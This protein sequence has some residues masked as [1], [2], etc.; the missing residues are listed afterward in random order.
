MESEEALN[1]YINEVKDTNNEIEIEEEQVP[2]E[3]EQA[4]DFLQKVGLSDLT[5]LYN[6]G[7]EITE[8]VVSDSVRQKHLTERQAET[9]RSRIRTLNKTLHSRQPRRKQRQDIRDVAWNVET[10]STGTRSR[11]AT[12]DSLD[13]VGILNDDLTSDEDQ[14]S[15]L[16]PFPLESS[17]PVFKAKVKWTSSEPLQ[18]KKLSRDK[19]DVAHLGSENVILKGYQPLNEYSTLPRPQRERSGSDPTTEVHLQPLKNRNSYECKPLNLHN[20]FSRSQ[21][22]CSKVYINGDENEILSFEGLMRQNKVNQLTSESFGLCDQGID[23]DEFTDSEY[24]YLKPLLY[25]ELVAIF[26]QYKIVFLKRKASTKYKGGNVFGV[27]LSTLVMRDMQRPTDNLMVP[28]IFQSVVN[29]LNTRCVCEDGILRLAGQKQKLEFLCNEIE[30][31]FFTSRLEVETLLAQATVHELTGVLKKLL[32]DLPDPV[33]TME[34]FDM[35]YKTSM[36]P[37]SEDK[38]KALNLLVLLLPIE[39]RNTYKLLLQFLLNVVKHE[40]QNR[41]NLHNVAMIT[42]PS[43]FPARLL[44]P[45]DNNSKLIM[46]Q[47][48]QEELAKHINGAAVCCVI[49]ETMLRAGL[50]LWLIPSYLARQAKEAQKRAQDKKDNSRDR[51]KRIPCGKTKLVR[52]STQYEPGPINSPRIKKDLFI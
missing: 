44:L 25:V 17:Q 24:Q 4:A 7:K 21:N 36:I 13:S 3:A 42:A 14:Q 5:K 46:K 20:E 30:S 2:N 18:N 38:L 49:M 41:M 40:K 33:F 11:S 16:P 51:D 39:H 1:Y 9:V 12:P 31:K 15:S 35:F 6:Q 37:N 50:K 29:Q 45:K 10:S 28:K 26:D 22:N 47:L 48:S 23:I 43:F 27:N 34:L 19:G 52:S 32:R 8:N